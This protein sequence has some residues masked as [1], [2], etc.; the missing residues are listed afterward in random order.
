MKWHPAEKL[1]QRE[2]TS[3]LKNIVFDGLATEAMTTLT[4]GTFLT[5][6]AIYLGASNI[7][8]GLL[9]SLPAMTNITQ[10]AAIWL[11]Q[12]YRNRR[13]IA[14]VSNA[15]ARF[16]LLLIGI[17]PL[18]FTAG[19]SI[20]ALIFLLFFHYLFGSLAGPG[21][22]SWMKDLIPSGKLGSFYSHRGRLMQILSVSLSLVMALVIDHVKL[23]HPGQEITM[24]AIMFIV[25]GVVGMA[26]VYF[27]SSTPE[28]K[29]TMNNDSL[30]LMM[31]KPLQNENFRRLMYFQVAWSFALNIAT[32]FY[33]VFVLKTLGIPI[34]Y[35][36]FLGIIT[37]LS[38]IGTIRLWGKFSDAYSNKT[39]LRIT[40]PLYAFCILC[41][42]I[43]EIPTGRS[44]VLVM[45]GLIHIAT[46]V[47]TAGINLS[48]GNIGLKLAP[49]EDAISYIVVRSML[50]AAFASLAPI[51][52]GALADF[53]VT[54]EFNIGFHLGSVHIQLL[55]IRHLGF[56]FILASAMAMLSMSLLNRVEEDGE[57]VVK[58]SILYALF[59]RRLWRNKL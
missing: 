41:W 10:L 42:T 32:P 39:I 34:S 35:L 14:V 29:T 7:Q 37:Q 31:K 27:L 46:G 8:I 11:V 45:L 51:V 19:A 38:S 16:P 15:M 26:G 52:G 50:M 24:Y 22:N 33:S 47:F 6:I 20:K 28:P 17:M 57:V 1:S 36:V 58:P 54:R 25:G 21:W 43:T 5:A 13:A 3:G 18:I 53:F 9:A 59:L 55:R 4:G 12:R 30:M 48:L 2:I 49:K 44:T 40:A 56:L 23:K